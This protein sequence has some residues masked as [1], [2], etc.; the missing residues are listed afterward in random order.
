MIACTQAIQ[1]HLE[2]QTE[3]GSFYDSI[4]DFD[5]TPR[6]LYYPFKGVTGNKVNGAATN[7]S[8]FV[9]GPSGPPNG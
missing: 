7:V 2:S 5:Y 4:D 3:F 1:V 9:G 8:S 6:K